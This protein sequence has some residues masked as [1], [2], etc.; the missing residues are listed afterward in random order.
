KLFLFIEE[1]MREHRFGISDLEALVISEGPGSYTGLRIGAS[2]VKGLLF[3]SR[4]P[5]YGVNTL[6]SFARAAY[7]SNNGLPRIHAVIDA[8]RKHLYHQ[9]YQ[10]EEGRL[11]PEEEVLVR[12]LEQ[13][14]DMLRKGDGLVGTGIK[15]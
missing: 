4:V 3:Q 15:R 10:G 13:V 12:P 8:R 2:A 6:R 9:L 11:K 1:L 7:S 5:L 14:A